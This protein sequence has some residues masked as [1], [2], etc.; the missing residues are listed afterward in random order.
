ML[1]TLSDFFIICGKYAIEKLFKIYW[2]LYKARAGTDVAVL[3][4]I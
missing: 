3:V 4:P 1:F 2:Q